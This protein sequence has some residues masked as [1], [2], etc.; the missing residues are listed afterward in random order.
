[1]ARA[2]GGDYVFADEGGAF[3]LVRRALRAALQCEEGWGAETTLKARLLQ[4]TGAPSAT[5]LLHAFYTAEYPR[6]RVATMAPQ[7]SE[8][9]DEG[10]EVAD[11]ILHSASAELVRY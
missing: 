11:S 7:V 6:T 3:D 4:A 5:A 1:M 9:A 8:A 10:D 2:G